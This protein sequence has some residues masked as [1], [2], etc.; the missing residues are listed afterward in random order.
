MKKKNE[1]LT[2][3]Q[4]QLFEILNTKDDV[5]S[6]STDGEEKPKIK[7]PSNE[8][9][10]IA[11]FSQLMELGFGYEI[12]LEAAKKFPGNL[13]EASQYLLTNPQP[14]IVQTTFENK[15][16]INPSTES[17]DEIELTENY[18]EFLSTQN[19]SPPICSMR[20]NDYNAEGLFKY[21]TFSKYL[22]LVCYSNGSPRTRLPPSISHLQF[23]GYYEKEVKTLKE[24]TEFLNV[25]EAM[26][27]I[28]EIEYTEYSVNDYYNKFYGMLVFLACRTHRDTS[29]FVNPFTSTDL[30]SYSTSNNQSLNLDYTLYSSYPKPLTADE[31]GSCWLKIQF[32][33]HTIFPETFTLRCGSGNTV[34]KIRLEGSIDNTNWILLYEENDKLLNEYYVCNMKINTEYTGTFTYI[35]FSIFSTA[36]SL[37]SIDFYGYSFSKNKNPTKKILD[38]PKNEDIYQPVINPAFSGSDDDPSW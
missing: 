25:R 38:E 31:T 11:G 23:L 5:S 10:E 22:H 3:E 18:I 1:N 17:I 9:F 2:P 24:P 20:I 7:G 28:R 27:I 33:K 21:S 13:E 29:T 32:L 30:I 12:T 34:A 26:N 14:T 19:N 35:K 8:D 36:A 6:H 16:R 4:Q 15:R 37:C